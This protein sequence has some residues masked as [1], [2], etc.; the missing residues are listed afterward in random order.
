ML[1]GG[2]VVDHQMKAEIFE[3][4]PHCWTVRQLS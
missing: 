1:V 4:V 3:L 2:I